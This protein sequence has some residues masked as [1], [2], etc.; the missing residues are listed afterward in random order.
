MLSDNTQKHILIVDDEQE[1]VEQTRHALTTALNCAVDVA[2]NGKEALDKLHKNV[3]Y[4]LL[5][6]DILVPKLNGIEVCEFMIRDQRLKQIPTL[7]ISILPLNSD[8]F[9]RSLIKFKEFAVVKDVLEKP[10]SDSDLLVKVGKIIG[11]VEK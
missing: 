1:V 6:L 7:L 3:H 2:Y 10:F 9:Q 8:D 11:K 5:I 4:D